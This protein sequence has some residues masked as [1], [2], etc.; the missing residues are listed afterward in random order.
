MF[1]IYFVNH[2]DLRRRLT[3][4]GFKGHPLRKDFPVTGFLETAYNDFHKRIVY[5]K[6][7]LAQEY[8]LFTLSNNYIILI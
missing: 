1:G 7:N 4:Y 8:R 2:P 6:V 5:G 3:D